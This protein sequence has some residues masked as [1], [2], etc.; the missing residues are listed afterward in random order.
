M[1]RLVADIGG[2]SARMGLVSGAGT[3]DAIEVVPC[4][5]HPSAEHC[6]HDYL[7]RR[8]AD[9]PE[10]LVV[11][12]AGPVRD[13]QVAFTN[14]AWVLDEIAL[15]RAF[16]GAPAR[17][18]ND[19][20]ALAAAL[21]VL[22]ATD[23]RPLG[24]AGAPTRAGLEQ[25]NCTVAL[26]GPGTGL[27]AAALLRRGG[28]RVTLASEAGH[29]HFAPADTSQ[30]ALLAQLAGEADQPVSTED[31]LSGPGLSRLHGAL[32][33]LDGAT[34]VRLPAAA[35]F[36]RAAAGD[37]ACAR[38]LRLHARLLGQAAADLVLTLGAWDGLFVAGGVLQRHPDALDEAAFRAGFEGTGAHAARLAGVP[39]AL[40]VHPWPGLLGAAILAREDVPC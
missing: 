8:G 21:P 33:V 36:E 24:A 16:G 15:R 26:L 28:H 23:L 1:T 32:R 19:F 12:A 27:G 40:V 7:R 22:E 2:T 29:V 18:V 34:D 11:A 17:V 39:A 13:G 10:A 6:L 9:A 5:E 3:I 4:A 14:S 37:A 31:V 20:E 25:A 38:T 30:R 35:I